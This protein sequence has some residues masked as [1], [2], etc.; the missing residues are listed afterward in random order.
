M[1]RLDG[2]WAAALVACLIGLARGG[3][4]GTARGLLVW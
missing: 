4:E 1:D 3:F 2:F